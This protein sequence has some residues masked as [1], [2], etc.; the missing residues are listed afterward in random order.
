MSRKTKVRKN[1]K[2]HGTMKRKR[3]MKGGGGEQSKPK[4]SV[5]I[6]IDK[7]IYE[8][9]KGELQVGSP[10]FMTC[11]NNDGDDYNVFLPNRKKIKKKNTDYGED[12]TV[13]GYTVSKECVK[14]EYIT[15]EKIIME[16]NHVR[17]YA[18]N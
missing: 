6:V 16:G 15:I 13:L 9:N 4:S 3:K 14:N 17:I 10:L 1:K 2:R 8:A 7:Y 5:E 11:V 12:P 18:H